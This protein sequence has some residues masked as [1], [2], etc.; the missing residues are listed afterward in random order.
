VSVT[1]LVLG[2]G[3]REHALA[4]RLA[5]EPDVGRVLVAPG[6]P[7]T[8]DV[9]DV[10][11]EV[12]ATDSLGVVA[13]CRREEVDLVVVGPEL[14]L[15][16]GLADELAAAG[17]ACL[18]PSAAAAR[19]EGSKAF[20]REVAQAAGVP[21]ADGAAFDDARE[22]IAFARRLGA[23]LV[24]KADGLAA[25]KGVT[26][27]E[28]LAE[29]EAAISEAMLES[30]FG[31]AGR[32]VV[33]ER[34][35]EGDEASLIALCDGARAL[36]LPPARDH[37]RLH[38]GDTGPNTGGMGAYS[39]LEDVDGEMVRAR[40]ADFHVAVLAELARRGTP[41]RGFL[42]AGLMLTP[43]GPRL[44]EFNV[45]LGDPEAQA[46]LPRLAGPLLPAFVAAASGRLD[47]FE[48]SLGVALPTEPGAAVA[49]TLAASGYPDAPR[50]GDAIGGL[51]EARAEG[52]LVFG[53]GVRRAP[54]G[55][56]GLV[57]AG[58]RVLTVV[59]QGDELAAARSVAYRAADRISFFGKQLRRDIG[60][61]TNAIREREVAIA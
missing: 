46:I 12:E 39:P 19:L 16:G 13:L 34:R 51:G 42:Y 3:A 17:V 2:S 29:G 26:V 37:K 40:L 4:W 54:G 20:C 32:R 6:N 8:G 10:V 14:P 11:P 52:A 7:L 43:D 44:L 45:R 53:A 49:L 50:G 56:G 25:G 61:G 31:A 35:L 28:S 9:A 27:C 47:E 5:R 24:V 30:R 22:A 18:G 59:G 36:M 38:D 48:A 60:I 23:P 57:T 55:D 33:V 21:M 15:V 58:G 41:F 1:V